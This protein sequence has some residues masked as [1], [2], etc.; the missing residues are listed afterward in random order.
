[1]L[2]VQRGRQRR[3][4]ENM[5][6]KKKMWPLISKSPLKWLSFNVQVDL[7]CGNSGLTPFLTLFL[8]NILPC[9]SIIKLCFLTEQRTWPQTGQ[10]AEVN[11]I[12]LLYPDRLLYNYCPV[13]SINACHYV[14]VIQL[15]MLGLMYSKGPKRHQF[16]KVTP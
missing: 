16:S 7:S 15:G 12:P 4:K 8:T 11:G 3:K 2:K 5:K 10:N 1:M 6:K 13:V 14:L 9:L